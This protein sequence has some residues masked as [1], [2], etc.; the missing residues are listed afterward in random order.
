MIALDREMPR[1]CLECPC[2][3]TFFFPDGDA[4]IWLR[5]CAANSYTLYQT[6]AEEYNTSEE[7][8]L[9]WI[10]FPKFEVCPWIE[11]GGNY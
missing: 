6:T 7:V 2:L 4:E 11:I 9:K 8:R 10:H 5:F 3:Q 1:H